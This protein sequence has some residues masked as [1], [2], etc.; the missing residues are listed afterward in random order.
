M[1]NIMRKFRKITEIMKNNIKEAKRGE[2]KLLE[3]LMEKRIPDKKTVELLTPSQVDKHKEE[4][5]K[6]LLEEFGDDGVP[7]K[8]TIE[9][10]KKRFGEE[11]AEEL[12]NEVI[13]S[14]LIKINSEDEKE[15]MKACS[16]LGDLGVPDKEVIN[17]LAERL[18]YDKNEYVR[19]AAL[20]S[21]MKLNDLGYALAAAFDRGWFEESGGDYNKAV[22]I[23]KKM[24]GEEREILID[25][26]LGEYHYLLDYL[27]GS[28]F[29][30]SKDK[31]VRKSVCEFLTY[32]GFKDERI[33]NALLERL[34]DEYENRDVKEAVARALENLGVAN[35]KVINTLLDRLKDENEGWEVRVAAARALG[36]LGTVRKVIEAKV[37]EYEKKGKLWNIVKKAIKYLVKSE[38]I[39]EDGDVINAL[40]KILK[41]ENEDWNVKAAAA[42]AL[43]KIAKKNNMENEILEIILPK[44]NSRNPGERYGVCLALG[45]L[46]IANEK[47]INALLERL[48]DKNESLWVRVA[49]IEDLDKLRA[50]NEEVINV[51]LRRLKD[52]DEEQYVKIAAAEVLGKIGVANDEVIDALIGRLKDKN[53]DVLVKRASTEALRKLGVAND[54]VINVL[55]GILNDGSERVLVKIAAAKALGNLGVPDEEVINTLLERLKD[56]KENKHVKQAA[57]TAL[58]QIAQKHPELKEEIG[59]LIAG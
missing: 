1:I 21:L 33:I 42:E 58:K 39:D 8:K 3:K 9:E 7:D 49:A 12:A 19:K 59:G 34:E 46:G 55:L 32:I 37:N 22:E 13:G 4:V 26:L 51:L 23:A 54:K 44:I 25:Y 6:R 31:N 15:R 27:L 40:L 57:K 56:E 35:D 43:G 2:A 24:K 20:G 17:A 14:L 11:V 53:E 36:E 5:V 29:I 38:I 48:E 47:I 45:E 18:R 28:Y 16:A 10:I 50:T 41:D 52:G 30:R